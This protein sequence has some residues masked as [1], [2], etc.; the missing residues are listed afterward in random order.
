MDYDPE[1]DIRIHE[2]IRGKTR[3]QIEAE[4]ME[5]N[6]KVMMRDAFEYGNARIASASRRR[7]ST[8]APEVQI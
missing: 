1:A 2:A 6:F 4:V 5:W 3:R 8:E 7:L